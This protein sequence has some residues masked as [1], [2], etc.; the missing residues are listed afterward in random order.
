MTSNGNVGGGDGIMSN[1]PPMFQISDPVRKSHPRVNV[2]QT[3]EQRK[4]MLARPL[5][6]CMFGRS[7][8]RCL[9]ILALMLS[10]WFVCEHRTDYEHYD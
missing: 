2:V 9:R 5:C 4:T 10:T 1:N 6:S 8:N 7:F 3:D